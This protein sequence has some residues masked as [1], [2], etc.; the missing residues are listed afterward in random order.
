MSQPNK[1]MKFK[2]TIALAALLLCA[3]L[4]VQTGCT[5]GSQRTAYNTIFSVEQTAT[6]AVDGY[7]ALV[8]N[9]TLTTNS[10][11]VVAKSFNTLQAACKIAADTSIAGTNALASAALVLEAT[12]L[13]ILIQNIELTTKK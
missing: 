8:L 6:L 2:I 9:G 11:P 10:V 1:T 7:F 4:M 3:S 5:T 12:D 13:G